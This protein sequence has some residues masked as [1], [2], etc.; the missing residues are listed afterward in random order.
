MKVETGEGGDRNWRTVCRWRFGS[1]LT[2]REQQVQADSDKQQATKPRRGSKT[3][4]RERSV[5]EDELGRM[6][7]RLGEELKNK[8]VWCKPEC[9]GSGSA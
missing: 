7:R 4:A 9:V 3:K 5:K 8:F 2:E 6:A 1:L